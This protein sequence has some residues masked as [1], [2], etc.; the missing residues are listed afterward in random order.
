MSARAP[1]R[2]T[3][4]RRPQPQARPTQ[5]GGDKERSMQSMFVSQSETG[6]RWKALGD[7]QPIQIRVNIEMD[8]SRP[9]VKKLKPVYDVSKMAECS[10]LYVDTMLARL[11]QGVTPPSGTLVELEE[12][13]T[14]TSDDVLYEVLTKD[15]DSG[16]NNLEKL[17]LKKMYMLPFEQRKDTFTD[18]M[19]DEV[20]RS[21]MLI[22]CSFMFCLS[23]HMNNENKV[24]RERMIKIV[25][26]FRVCMICEMRDVDMEDSTETEELGLMIKYIVRVMLLKS[27]AEQLGL[28]IMEETR[29]STLMLGGKVYN[30]KLLGMLCRRYMYESKDKLIERGI[31]GIAIYYST[32]GGR[33]FSCVSTRMVNK[34]ACRKAEVNTT[35]EVPLALCALLGHENGFLPCVDIMYSLNGARMKPITELEMNAIVAS[36]NSAFKTGYK[37]ECKRAGEGFIVKKIDKNGFATAMYDYREVAEYMVDVS[38]FSAVGYTL[39]KMIKNQIMENTKIEISMWSYCRTVV[40]KPSNVKIDLKFQE[41]SKIEAG[42]NYDEELNKLKERFGEL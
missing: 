36:L 25:D 39:A 26:A 11:N 22:A 29:S 2:S 12:F 3:R 9:Y 20:H 34:L 13:R 15:L 8:E 7:Q 6:R 18:W 32:T 28:D 42:F 40:F 24:V 35:H 10:K 17:E 23:P 19:S 33:Q 31:T 1:P 30:N 37:L 38:M 14:H 41:E 16:L 4:P 5:G 27:M 21:D